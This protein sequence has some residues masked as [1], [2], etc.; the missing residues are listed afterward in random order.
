[1]LELLSRQSALRR[2]Q[3]HI[4]RCQTSLL[5][6]FDQTHQLLKRILQHRRTPSFFHGSK[7]HP[8]PTTLVLGK[9]NLRFLPVAM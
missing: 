1:M 7:D 2:Q 6:G 9:T 5:S 3:P 4:R 8:I